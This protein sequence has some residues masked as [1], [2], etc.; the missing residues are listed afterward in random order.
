MPWLSSRSAVASRRR[1]RVCWARRPRGRP[2]IALVEAPTDLTGRQIIGLTLMSA[3]GLR[4]P[5]APATDRTRTPLAAGAGA[6]AAGSGAEPAVELVAGDGPGQEVALGHVA[7]GLTQR[8]QH[9]V[10]L[11]ALGDDA[12][13]EV[14]TELD[15]GADD[16]GMGR[17]DDHVRDEALVDLQLVQRQRRQVP[18]RGLTL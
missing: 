2:S 5:C 11:D 7:P 14:V 17:V 8:V 10:G 4:R 13:R 6:P 16:G 18:E 15:D 12:Q 3:F 9:V 1:R